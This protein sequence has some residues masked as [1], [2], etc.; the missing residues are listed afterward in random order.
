MLPQ[1]LSASSRIDRPLPRFPRNTESLVCSA[2]PLPHLGQ[3]G[4]LI[5]EFNPPRKQESMC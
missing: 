1:Y 2:P 3:A 4:A 5:L